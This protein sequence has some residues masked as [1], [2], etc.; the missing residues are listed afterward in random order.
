MNSKE[1]NLSA[2]FE[3]Q[4]LNLLKKNK[5]TGFKSNPAMREAMLG[6]GVG[7]AVGLADAMREDG[8]GNIEEGDKAS[9]YLKSILGYGAAG[10]GIGGG[11]GLR[12]GLKLQHRAAKSELA[13]MAP[14]IE[15]RLAMGVNPTL[16]GEARKDVLKRIEEHAP[17]L[18]YETFMENLSKEK[19]QGGKVID[20]KPDFFERRDINRESE[21]AN[22]NYT[23]GRAAKTKADE[24][25]AKADKAMSDLEAKMAPKKRTDEEIIAER[26]REQPGSSA[27]PR[28]GVAK[29]V[30]GKPTPGGVSS[31]ERLGPKAKAPV[32]P[33]T[34][35][36]N[37]FV[38]MYREGREALQKH[39]DLYHS[40]PANR[41]HLA[42][43]VAVDNHL[44]DIEAFTHTM[45]S[46]D[47]R[48]A[49]PLHDRIV[50]RHGSLI[51]NQNPSGGLAN[52]ISST[53]A[54][55]NKPKP[56]ENLL[57]N[58]KNKANPP[59]ETIAGE[60]SSAIPSPT[61]EKV[62]LRDHFPVNKADNEATYGSSPRR[63]K[64]MKPSDASAADA[65]AQA[66]NPSL[67]DQENADRL[68]MSLAKYLAMMD[69]AP[70]V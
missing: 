19:S 31:F 5:L 52:P 61:G 18:D 63:R 21:K 16:M 64:R 10:A 66:A 50:R 59:A 55:V 57:T 28:P 27:P 35:P 4:I 9:K 26:L 42:N 62:D 23:E 24:A 11:V 65:R 14:S 69:K 2:N 68:N 36:E 49:Q 33:I 6:G 1:A 12:K 43:V 60:A 58:R 48:K 40:D 3:N 39:K 20:K 51:G 30:R 70:T 25:Q 46:G 41:V 13:K 17:S 22:K 7:G 44:K 47:L 54:P 29:A 34:P 32:A 37:H 8:N 15:K 38:K 56:F 45:N 67:T 53:A